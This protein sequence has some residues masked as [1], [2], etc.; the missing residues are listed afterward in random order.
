[1]QT[2]TP[3]KK[4]RILFISFIPVLCFGLGYY[5]A[6]RQGRTDLQHERERANQI[7]NDL[8]EARNAEQAATLR[9]ERL[10]KEIDGATKRIKQLQSRVDGFVAT[11]GTIQSGID[12]AIS[13]AN[14]S[15]R[16]ISENAS[17]LR[18]IQNRGPTKN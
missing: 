5:T 7:T 11:I 10:Q 18:T 8:R 13:G 3:I 9:A 6:Y 14:E 2:K 16:L 12:G 17:I 4:I 1:M 15:Q